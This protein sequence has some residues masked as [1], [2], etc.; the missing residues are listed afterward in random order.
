MKTDRNFRGRTAWVTGAGSGIGAAL[1]TT[2][3]ARGTNVVAVDRDADRLTE[4]QEHSPAGRLHCETVD[5]TDAEAVADSVDGLVRRHGRLDYVFNN[6]G[7]GQAGAVSD[8][9][10]SDWRRC[11]DVN[12][13]GVING[14]HAAWPHLVAQGRGHIVNTASG[15]G[16]VPRPGMV[17]YS[18]SKWAVVGLSISLREEAAALGIR[19]S[20]ACPGHIQTRIL[21]DADMPGLDRE[22][23]L[24]SIP[25][26]GIA[27]EDCARIMLRGVRA[28]RAVIPVGG[29]INAEWR[30]YRLAPPVGAALGRVRNRMMLRHRRRG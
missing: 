12:I 28:N 19:V 30:L 10:L 14:I 7:I 23:L 2:L 18:M 29:L 26:T 8:L 25:G 9:S 6:A 5:V 16:L 4:L 21:D 27:A 15:A 1:V 22:S 24:S 3:L 11:I 17:P 13:G 20:A